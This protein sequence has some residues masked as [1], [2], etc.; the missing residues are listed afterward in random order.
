MAMS[1]DQ[2]LSF[3]QRST[4]QHNFSLG[5]DNGNFEP[6]DLGWLQGAEE[7]LVNFPDIN[8]ESEIFTPLD[9]TLVDA[10]ASTFM[11]SGNLD[12][13]P[14]ASFMELSSGKV[15]AT[16]RSKG[17]PKLKDIRGSGNPDVSWL[18]PSIHSNAWNY[19]QRSARK[20]PGKTVLI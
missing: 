14:N 16:K 4:M 18:C 2:D 20:S 5:T 15:K 19:T 17:R 1:S 6:D 3:E 8:Q 13:G 7:H 9:P 12:L 11:G 10:S